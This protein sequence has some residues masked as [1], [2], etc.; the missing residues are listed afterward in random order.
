MYLRL[1]ILLFLSSIL[2]F[3]PKE[4]KAELDYMNSH[5]IQAESHVS[6]ISDSSERSNLANTFGYSVKG[7]YHFTNWGLFFQTEQNLWIASEFSRTIKPGVLNIAL[8]SEYIYFEGRARTSLALGSSIL[9]FDTVLDKSG[10]KG[11]FMDL[12]PVGF[13]WNLKDFVYILF[14]PLSVA[15]V[16]PVLN[17]IPLVMVEYRTVIS[18]EYNL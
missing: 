18:L 13:K 2:V 8:G 11:I 10:S 5:Y 1:I 12:R 6:I 7:G 14:D 15:I 17:R 16:A 9:L 4:L 3:N